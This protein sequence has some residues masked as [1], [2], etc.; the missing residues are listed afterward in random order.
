MTN[1]IYTSLSGDQL[2]SVHSDLQRVVLESGRTH[3]VS[4]IRSDGHQ[5]QGQV[6][7]FQC[8]ETPNSLCRPKGKEPRCASW[9]TVTC[10]KPTPD[11]R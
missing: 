8:R 6:G 1:G 9:Q 10:R 4:L 11:L 2:M 3:Q 7:V 5:V